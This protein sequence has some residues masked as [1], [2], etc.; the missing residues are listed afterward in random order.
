ML[1][2]THIFQYSSPVSAEGTF[3]FSRQYIGN[4]YNIR[5]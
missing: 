5:L 4:E 1:A 3:D 2:V